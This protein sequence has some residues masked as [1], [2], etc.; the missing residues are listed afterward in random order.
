MSRYQPPIINGG[1]RDA[2]T[3]SDLASYYLPQQPFIGQPAPLPPSPFE[4]MRQEYQSRPIVVN[5]PTM[6]SFQPSGQGGTAYDEIMARLNRRTP[7]REAPSAPPEEESTSAGSGT[8]VYPDSVARMPEGWRNGD[9]DNGAARAML[10]YRMQQGT[11]RGSDGPIVSEMGYGEGTNTGQPVGIQTNGSSG[12]RGSYGL[13]EAMSGAGPYNPYNPIT[14]VDMAPGAAAADTTT[15]WTAATAGRGESQSSSSRF[16]DS[17]SNV[18][19]AAGNFAQFAAAMSMTFTP[20]QAQEVWEDFQE[21]ER[22]RRTRSDA[23][24]GPE[25]TREVNTNE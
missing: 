9:P 22:R 21:A 6:P 10:A 19:R 1:T 7:V 18:A 23:N 3:W 2:P 20:T 5:Q 17:V 16:W 15:G 8:Y 4:S 25:E 24:S 14:G 11:I 12:D 13:G